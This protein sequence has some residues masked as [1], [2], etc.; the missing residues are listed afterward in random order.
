[1]TNTHYSPTPPQPPAPHP[2]PPSGY[3]SESTPQQSK[4]LGISAMVTGIVALVLAVIPIIGVVS[5]V[6]GLVAI[7]LGIFAVLK[8]KG[9]GQGIAGIITGAASLVLALIVSFIVGAFFS[10]VDQGLRDVQEEL[11]RELDEGTEI[12]LDDTEIGALPETPQAYSALTVLGDEEALP[13]G[14]DGEVSVVAISEPENNTS[15]GFIVQNQT[16]QA[17]SRIEVSG[18][19]ISTDGETLGTGASHSVFP[20]VVLPGGYAFGYVYVDTSE[21]SL[22]VGASIP[23]LRIDYTEGLGRFENMIGVDIENFEELASGDLTGDVVNPHASA[24]SGPIAIDT[25]CLTSDER[26]IYDGTYSDNDTV[27]AGGSSTWTMSF[28]SDRP[29]CAVR[30]LSA[31]GFE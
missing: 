17:V 1:M 9:K 27:E 15:F 10:A 26:V 14:T 28:Y 7:G 2:G 21:H 6:L 5:F 19:A 11:Q 18:R 16:D 30:L 31:R 20:N 22:P 24:V 23:E 4:G 25:V 29:E 3:T 12:S 8:S 13:E